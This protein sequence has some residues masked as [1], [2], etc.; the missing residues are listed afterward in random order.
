MLTCSSIKDCAS[1][2]YDKLLFRERNAVKAHLCTSYG[3]DCNT[4][5]IQIT[6]SDCSC[7]Q[8]Q[9]AVSVICFL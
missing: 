8:Q 2:G 4:D 3:A 7:K 6:N 9:Q 5:Q 1:V